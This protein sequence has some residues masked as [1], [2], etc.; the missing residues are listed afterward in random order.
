MYTYGLQKRDGNVKYN[1][2]KLMY[3]ILYNII[4]FQDDN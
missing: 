2:K 1:I 3:G 4:H